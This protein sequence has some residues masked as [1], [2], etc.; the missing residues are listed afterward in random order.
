[1]RLRVTSQRAVCHGCF[2]ER[3][4]VRIYLPPL[5]TRRVLRSDRGGRVA[6]EGG[7]DDATRRHVC[8]LRNIRVLTAAERKI[9]K[10][11][12]V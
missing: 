10:K 1:M 6:A 9:K 11:G 7:C 12:G 4:P 8:V 2:I 3:T 5:A